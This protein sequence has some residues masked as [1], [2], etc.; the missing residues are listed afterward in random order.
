MSIF[1]KLLASVGI[2]SAQVDT[3]LY[4]ES[5]LPGDTVAGEVH[6]TGGELAQEID[7]IYIYVMTHYERETKDQKAKENCV[8]LKYLISQPIKLEPGENRSIPF[9]FQLPWETPLTMGRQPVYL[10]T[11][12]DIKNAV[13]PGDSDFIEVRPHPLMAKT[14]EAVKLLG[15]QLYK[16]DCEYN[17]QLGRKY[18]FVQEFEFRPTGRYR[19]RLEELELIFFLQPEKLEVL[20]ELDKRAKGM[21]GLFAEK[22]NLDERYM[23]FHLR[24][25][26]QHLTAEQLAARIGALIEQA[27]S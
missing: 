12:L 7:E 13:D 26:D 22:F 11:G 27:I 4:H 5:F 23:R 16:V 3:R 18:P 2:G 25:D 6:L 17:R 21:L 10:R 1:K 9:S 20:L 14:L 24:A 15:F 8:L 19:Q